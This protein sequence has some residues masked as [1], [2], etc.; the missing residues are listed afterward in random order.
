MILT[1]PLEKSGHEYLIH[2]IL[3]ADISSLNAQKIKRP[4]KPQLPL[5]KA[6][7]TTL[8]TDFSP[9]QIGARDRGSF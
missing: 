4:S 3:I 1:G 9:D 5:T 8:A 7:I 6:S 2:S